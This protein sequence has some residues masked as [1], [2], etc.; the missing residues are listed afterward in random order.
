MNAPALTCKTCPL[1]AL[2][3]RRRRR[4]VDFVFNIQPAHSCRP[5][6]V[7]VCLFIILLI[8]SS[9]IWICAHA[10]GFPNRGGG[11]GSR[12]MKIAFVAEE[13]K[14]WILYLVVNHKLL[15]PH[16]SLVVV[17]KFC[18]FDLVSSSI[19]EIVAKY[20]WRNS[21]CDVDWSIYACCRILIYNAENEPPGVSWIELMQVV[22]SLLRYVDS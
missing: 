21:C 17:W 6:V 3:H 20:G 22:E 16:A 18:T 7:Y 19:L 11:P 10:I 2:F 1:Q 9:N 5:C 13:N 12:A 8:I 15:P 14:S 4:P